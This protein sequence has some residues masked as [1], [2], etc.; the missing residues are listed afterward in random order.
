MGYK[1][2]FVDDEED[3]LRVLK[4]YFEVQGYL[5]YTASSGY[6][7]LEKL[8]LKPDI[9]LL[10]I[11][12]PR[13]DGFEL[14]QKIR[15][16]VSCPIIF[17]SAKVEERDRIHG[18]MV[19]GDD[20]IVKP[21]SMEELSARIAAH[22]RRDNRLVKKDE[23]KF[24]DGFVI[25]YMEKC[26]YFGCEKVHLTK[27][28]FDIIEFLSVNRGQVFTKERMY[29][30]LWGYD[31]EGD[32]NIITEHIRR[33]RLKLGKYSDASLIETVWGVGYKWIG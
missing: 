1:I 15:E 12:M 5:I 16:Y 32:S 17:L 28:E 25:N 13:M 7:A 2:L 10:D 24:I 30:K 26:L 20:Y 18:L 22:I 27:T 11:N 8:E 33:I 3:I 14:C 31:S 19:G 9:V 23:L 6:E 4:D 21:F 29:E